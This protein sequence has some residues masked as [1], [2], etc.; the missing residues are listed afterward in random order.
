MPTVAPTAT[1]RRNRD[2]HEL[3]IRI[4]ERRA[5][6]LAPTIGRERRGE[7]L[8]RQWCDCGYD[9]IDGL[10]ISADTVCAVFD[11]HL[12]NMPG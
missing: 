11:A 9:T 10:P 3:Q 12:P 5:L 7:W 6:H 8:A 1:L 4:T 2:G